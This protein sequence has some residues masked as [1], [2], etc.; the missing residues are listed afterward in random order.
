MYFVVLFFLFFF[1]REW[2]CEAPCGACPCCGR[3]DGTPRKR[4]GRPQQALPSLAEYGRRMGVPLQ[5]SSLLSP[6]PAAWPHLA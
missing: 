1:L 4:A 6:W 2:S 3:Q 5:A